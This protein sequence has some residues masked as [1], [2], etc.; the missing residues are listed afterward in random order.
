MHNTILSEKKNLIIYFYKHV[1]I[2]FNYSTFIRLLYNIF[3]KSVVK[4]NSLGNGIISYFN[5]KQ[6]NNRLKEKN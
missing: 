6:E 1:I 5:T 4:E 3:F 2:D